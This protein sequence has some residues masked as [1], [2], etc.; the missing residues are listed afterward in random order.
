MVE[1]GSEKGDLQKKVIKQ[2]MMEY[3]NPQGAIRLIR[4]N[5]YSR[6]EID[7]LIKE[8]L[9]EANE[10][11]ILQKRQFDIG[12]MRYLTYEEW[13]KEYFIKMKNKLVS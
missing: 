4:E 2:L 8:V 5:R 13:L 9:E 10:R 6:E 1:T 12:T 3:R 7:R 11:G